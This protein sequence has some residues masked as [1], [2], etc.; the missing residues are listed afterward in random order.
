MEPIEGNV[1]IPVGFSSKK[2]GQY[3]V[4]ASELSGLERYAVEL[5]DNVSGTSVSL[6]VGET[7]TFEA[8]AGENASRFSL[9][10]KANNGS[11]SI[12][13]TTGETISVTAQPSAIEVSTTGKATIVV[14]DILGRMLTSIYGQSGKTVIPVNNEGI[15]F[16]DV[17]IGGIH[18]TEKVVI[19]K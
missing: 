10:L 13:E 16:V 15:Y 7:H 18:K 19:F 2:A 8:Q 6:S 5:K 12:G 4:T 3:T 14:T 1:T 9:I 11:T 17:T